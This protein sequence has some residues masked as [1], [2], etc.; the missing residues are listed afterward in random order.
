V[1]DQRRKRQ[2]GR[3]RHMRGTS[4]KEGWNGVTTQ[5]TLLKAGVPSQRS[6]ASASNYV[7]PEMELGLVFVFIDSS[8]QRQS[9][10][11]TSYS[12]PGQGGGHHTCS[13]HREAFW[14]G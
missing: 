7:S 8:H 6:E 11:G 13:R 5:K 9:I 2:K 1:Q 12:L 4:A 14:I 3:Q 10:A